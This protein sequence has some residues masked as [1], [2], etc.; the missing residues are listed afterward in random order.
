[1]SWRLAL[2]GLVVC[3]VTALAASR[4][5]G[6]NGDSASTTTRI[7]KVRREVVMAPPSGHE[8]A[9]SIPSKPRKTMPRAARLSPPERPLDGMTISVDPGHNGGNFTHLEE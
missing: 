7:V 9:K 4:V 6:G 8:P 2:L 1:M 3:G 5:I